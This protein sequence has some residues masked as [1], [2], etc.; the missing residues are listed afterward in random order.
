[1]RRESSRQLLG[2]LGLVAALG[3]AGATGAADPAQ[4]AESCANCHGKDGVSTEA[5]VPTIAGLSAQYLTDSMNAYKKKQRPC[6]ETKYRAGAKKGQATDM[7]KTAAELSDADVAAVAKLLAGKK[8]VRAKQSFDAAAAKK[9][10]R[11]DLLEIP[12]RRGRRPRRR[13]RHPRRPAQSVSGRGVQGIHVRQAADARED[14]AESGE[15]AASRHRCARELLRQ[16]SVNRR[17]RNEWT[18]KRR[19]LHGRHER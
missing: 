17:A 12:R 15:A 9:A 10:P 16:L 19:R 14:E 2:A 5:D 6:P 18:R 13:R 1:M 7:C 8:F 3:Y 4:I 11:R